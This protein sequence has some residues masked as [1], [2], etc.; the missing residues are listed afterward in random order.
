MVTIMSVPLQSVWHRVKPYIPEL[1]TKGR[2]NFITIHYLYICGMTLLGS[3]IIFAIGDIA[4]IDALVFGSGG[5]TQSGLN[6]VDVNSIHTAQQFVLYVLGNVCNPIVIHSSV[7]FIRLHWFEKRFK[8][9]VEE[10]RMLRRSKSRSRVV[11]KTKDDPELG[12]QEKGVRGRSIVV[13][14]DGHAMEGSLEDERAKADAAADSVSSSSAHNESARGSADTAQGEIPLVERIQDP[15]GSPV[16]L[17]V[18]RHIAFLEN[19]RSPKDKGALRIPSPRE[20]D[21]GGRPED[22]GDEEAAALTR[23]ATRRTGSNQFGA[24]DFGQTPQSANHITINEPKISRSRER[25]PP[26]PEVDSDK[27]G[28]TSSAEA[29]ASMFSRVRSRQGRN[30]KNLV[31][32]STSFLRSKE[33][34]PKDEAPYLSWVPTIVRNSAFVN[35]NEQQR[36][37]LGGIEYRALKTLAIVL[38]SYYAAF[39]LLGLICLTPWLMKSGRYGPIVNEFG[40]GRP[41]WGVF[42]AAS[43]FNDLGFTLT[44]DSMISFGSAVFPLLLMTFLILIG[45]TGFPCMLRFVIWFTSKLAPRGSGLWEELQFL[46]DHPRRCFTLLFP[47]AATWWLFAILVMLNTVDVILFI[48]LDVSTSY[49]AIDGGEC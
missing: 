40:V 37:E 34:E 9:V 6:T 21:R 45:N 39:H 5:S 32:V 15:S 17:N 13:L 36:E 49:L 44:P 18:D 46:L 25:V 12:R 3:V 48:I 24:M 23:K 28:T 19:Q 1:F 43:A 4:Y 14:R 29:S 33:Q 42:T 7:V 26:L 30:L 8:H 2:F 41:W 16:Q 27:V 31:R 47:R 35:L 22:V 11:S 10:A 20:F 38:L